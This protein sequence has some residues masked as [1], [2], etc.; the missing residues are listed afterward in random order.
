[1]PFSINFDRRPHGCPTAHRRLPPPNSE[2]GKLT[3][4]RLGLLPGLSRF[5]EKF[6]IPSPTLTGAHPK[7]KDMR[8]SKR[9]GPIG[10]GCV[11]LLADHLDG[12][13]VLT[14]KFW[15]FL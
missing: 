6:L 9:D 5:T 12:L 10:D 15:A 14:A 7:K 8:P 3:G 13:G 11:G 4:S 1:M 2:V